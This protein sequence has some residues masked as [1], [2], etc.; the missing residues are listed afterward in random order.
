[1]NYLPLFNLQ[2][3][4]YALHINS[5]FV[6]KAGIFTMMDIRATNTTSMT[7]QCLKVSTNPITFQSDQNHHI[8]IIQGRKTQR[9]G[10]CVTTPRFTTRTGTR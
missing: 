6:V 10:S 3:Y 4:L 8:I 7:R 1:M 2:I 5:C 9:G